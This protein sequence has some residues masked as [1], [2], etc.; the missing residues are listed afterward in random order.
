VKAEKQEVDV[1]AR[2]VEGLALCA[3]TFNYIRSPSC[4]NLVRMYL[5]PVRR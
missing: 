2:A 4:I 3:N 5:D 1:K